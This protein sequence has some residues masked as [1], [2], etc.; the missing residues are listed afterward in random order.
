MALANWE[1]PALD[2]LLSR[3]NRQF[4]EVERSLRQLEGDPM[5]SSCVA[6]ISAT[7]GTLV[8]SMSDLEQILKRETMFK[9][10]HKAYLVCYNWGHE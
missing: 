2:V 9:E 6:S 5:D 4:E 3:V 8:K 7:L 1:M 10:Q